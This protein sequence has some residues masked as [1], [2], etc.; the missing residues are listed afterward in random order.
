M[1]VYGMTRLQILIGMNIWTLWRTD[2]I[3]EGATGSNCNWVRKVDRQGDRG[4]RSL[5]A[6]IRDEKV[7]A[8]QVYEDTAD[9]RQRLHINDE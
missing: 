6:K 5:A 9:N 2:Y 7:A 3:S 8:W 4:T 1:G